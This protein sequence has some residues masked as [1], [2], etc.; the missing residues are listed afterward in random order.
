MIC[1]E[2]RGDIL[3]RLK[4]RIPCSTLRHGVRG[5]PFR[6]PRAL[7]GVGLAASLLQ[8]GPAF[9][10]AV[11]PL[12]Q[13]ELDLQGRASLAIGSGARAL[14]MGGAFLARA[15]DAT[16]ASWN[17][18]GLSYLRTPELRLVGVRNDLD[19]NHFDLRETLTPADR[20][21]GP[22]PDFL[23]LAF[24]FEVGSVAG[25][26]Q[27]SFQRAFS[28]DGRRTIRRVI[29]QVDQPVLFDIDGVGGLDVLA[30]G[31]GVQVSRTLRLG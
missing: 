21:N 1:E 22:A 12:P 29:T 13:D 16:A 19:A 7:R 23:S 20:T 11:T 27:G 24:P 3:S 30:L 4:A 6:A 10:Q 26:V 17:P 14:G 5:R 31:T 8:A 25:A 2:G 28:F 9:A 18:A 15:D